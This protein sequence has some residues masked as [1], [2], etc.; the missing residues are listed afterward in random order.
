MALRI[1][2][3][4][5]DKIRE[6]RSSGMTAAC[7]AQQLNISAAS[8]LRH[9]SDLKRTERAELV[10]G[11]RFC[12]ADIPLVLPCRAEYKVIEWFQRLY[13]TCRTC[14]QCYAGSDLVGV[15]TVVMMLQDRFE[16]QSEDRLESED[17]P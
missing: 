16:E 1:T 14:G 17:M 5:V 2:Q 15:D 13:V 10:L 7:I 9:A 8:V 3:E 12:G 4:M 6:L 11:C